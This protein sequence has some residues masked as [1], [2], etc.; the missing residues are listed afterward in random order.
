MRAQCDECGAVKDRV[1][2]ARVKEAVRILCLECRAAL[3]VPYDDD[4]LPHELPAGKM[5]GV[6][7]KQE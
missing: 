7:I 6:I 5:H 2:P 4:H 1:R 3:G